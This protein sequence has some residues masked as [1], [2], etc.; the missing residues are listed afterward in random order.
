MKLLGLC[1]D[2]VFSLHVWKCSPQTVY[3]RPSGAIDIKK[4]TNAGDLHG[5]FFHLVNL[6][7]CWR[8]YMKYD[9]CGEGIFAVH[10]LRTSCLVLS[11][12]HLD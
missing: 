3:A 4:S 5:A 1:Y 7:E 12:L 11:I 2:N 10:D 8:P 6:S 9:I